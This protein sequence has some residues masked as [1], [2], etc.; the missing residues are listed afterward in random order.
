MLENM[1]WYGYDS[2]V[3]KRWTYVSFIENDIGINMEV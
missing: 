1:E 2:E 3:H